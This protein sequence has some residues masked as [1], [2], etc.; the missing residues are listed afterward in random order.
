M[1]VITHQRQ[2]EQPY[3]CRQWRRHESF[4][5]G[6]P[7]S[8]ENTGSPNQVPRNIAMPEIGIQRVGIP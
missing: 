4:V 5:K 6:V 2:L 8:D 1:A 3:G 7:Y